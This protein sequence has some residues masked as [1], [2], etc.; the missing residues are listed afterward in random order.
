MKVNFRGIPAVTNMPERLTTSAAKAL[1]ACASPGMN[2]PM[3]HL[4]GITPGSAT[5]EEAFGGPVPHDVVRIRITLDDVRQ[6][7]EH[8][9]TAKTDKVDIVHMG[10]PHLT[11][12]EIR[13]IAR[14]I[15][16]KKVHPEVMMWVQTDTP[17]YHMARHYG[18]AK[19]IEE[20][21]AKIYHQTCAGMDML[22]VDWGS[23]FNVAT[24]SFKQVKIF[25]GLGHGMIFASLPELIDAAI[26][27][28]Y[29]SSRWR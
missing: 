3:L 28:R 8:L 20:A 2:D 13:Q 19:I 10:C 15:K 27:G 4:I 12:E 11:Y 26:T 22:A 24:N 1:T 5:L 18:E 7:Y 14:A 9:R 21:G 23:D 25:G 17:S 29:Q 16:G 6:C